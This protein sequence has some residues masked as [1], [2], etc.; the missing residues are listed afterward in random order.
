MRKLNRKVIDSGSGAVSYTP[1]KSIAI[2]FEGQTLPKFIYL[3]MVRYE[4]SPL[5]SKPSLCFSCFRYG[6]IKAQKVGVNHA[7][8]FAETNSM[9]MFLLAQKMDNLL[10]ASIAKAPTEPV[11]L[12][13]LNGILKGV[14]LNWWPIQIFQ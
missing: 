9:R 11:I 5:V 1:S 7:I 13:A 14:F 4:V 8:S 12:L 10:L 6:H 3:F 2:T